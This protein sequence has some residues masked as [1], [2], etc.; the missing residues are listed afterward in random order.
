[1][2]KKRKREES[3]VKI[4]EDATNYGEFI[5]SY[6]SWVTLAKQKEKAGELEK[7]TK[8]KKNNK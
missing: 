5:S 8:N 7:I 4:G 6:F 3:D 1:M 2:D